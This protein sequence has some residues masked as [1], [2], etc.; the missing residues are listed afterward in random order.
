MKRL[1]CICFIVFMVLPS[2]GQQ[3]ELNCFILDPDTEGMTNIRATP[4]GK[5]VYQLDPAYYALTA[6]IPQQGNW[7][8]IKDAVV[9]SYGDEIKIP[10]KEAWIHRS[11]LAV[12]TDSDDGQPKS[13][14]A[15][16]RADAPRLCVIHEL[17]AI[18]RP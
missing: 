14:L 8:R 13:L 12:A 2:Y 9:Q 7:W 1:V 15:E 4:G 3:H 6:I 16:P 17:R 18:L 5:V 11:I 10:G